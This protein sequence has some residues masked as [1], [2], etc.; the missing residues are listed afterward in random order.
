MVSSAYSF[1]VRKCASKIIHLMT[2]ENT[3]RSPVT[4]TN[5]QIRHLDRDF[6]CQRPASTAPDRV[7]L[8]W[9]EHH[10]CAIN[11]EVKGEKQRVI[12]ISKAGSV[13]LKCFGLGEF[14]FPTSCSVLLP[15]RISCSFL[16]LCSQ[17][18]PGS[19][20]ITCAI[21]CVIIARCIKGVQS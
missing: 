5:L 6:I 7:F 15:L 14:S 17:V 1:L 9:F 12:L 13:A 2:I 8:R 3:I 16:E 19:E 10:D 11:V 4:K 21:F 18:Q 20:T